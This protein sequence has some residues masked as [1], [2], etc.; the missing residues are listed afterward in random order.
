MRKPSFGDPEADPWGSPDLHRG[1][2]HAAAPNDSAASAPARTTSP[3]TTHSTTPPSTTHAPVAP[4][5]PSSLGSEGGWGGFGAPLPP[6]AN[7]MLGSATGSSVEEVVTVTALPEKE[8]MFMFQHRNYQVASS[9][10]T[11]QVVR[12]YSDFVWLLDCLHKR[13]PFRQLPLLPPKRVAINGTPLAADASFLEKRRKG[14]QRFTNSLVRHPVLNQEQLVVMFLTV[15]T[16]LAVW[17]K[18]ANLSIVEEFAGKTLP[19]DLEDSLPNTLPDLFDTVR[20]GVRRSAETYITLCNMMERLARRNQGMAAEYLR[21]STAL[22]TL[23]ET[24]QDTYAVDTNDVPLLNQ[25]LHA[26]ARHLDQSKQLL[27]DEA[28]GWEAGVLEDLKRQRDTL[29][30]VRDMFDRRD[31]YAKDNIPYLEKRIATNEAKLQTL[32][33]KPV[34]Q[35]KPG[36]AEKVEDAISKDKSSIVAQHARSL[37]IKK[38]LRDELV[39]FHNTLRHVSRLQ[40]DWA[41]ERVKYAEL[42]AHN[43][44]AWAEL[45]DGMASS[46]VEE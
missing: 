8:G 27:E 9:R 45:L 44:R 22:S 17:R 4:M 10:R 12:R 18:Q 42:Q 6:P 35:V 20:S 16:E 24:S 41:H 3:F 28:L 11:T 39:F 46:F 7:P 32:R 13:Y 26:T 31:K 14:L 34:D 29:V 36:E 15:P 21:F 30:S 1:H 2:H 23:R 33:T 19:P 5:A 37:F 40:H 38:C 25:G 43:W